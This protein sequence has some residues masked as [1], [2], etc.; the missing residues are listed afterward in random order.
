MWPGDTNGLELEPLP[1]SG[2]KRGSGSAD[3]LHSSTPTSTAHNSSSPKIL[4][5]SVIKGS[6][7][8]R[9][10]L[11]LHVTLDST[12][13]IGDSQNHAGGYHYPHFRH[14]EMQA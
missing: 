4:E 8:K 14:E 11:E 3:S 12:Q 7:D 2:G 9:L 13:T 6:E 1:P 10:F 5:Y